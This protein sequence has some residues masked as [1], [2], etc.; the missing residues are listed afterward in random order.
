ME[1]AANKAGMPRTSSTLSCRSPHPATS[2]NRARSDTTAQPDP[3]RP[4]RAWNARRTRLECHAHHQLYHVDL[5]AR[6]LPITE[7][8]ATQLLNRTRIG[9]LVHG[10]RGEQGWN[11]TH[12]INLIMSTSAPGYFR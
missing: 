9:L 6:L 11:A 2:D 8:E 5:R 10:M 7:Q 4:P 12:I 1:C 3:D